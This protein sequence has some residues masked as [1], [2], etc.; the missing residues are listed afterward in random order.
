MSVSSALLHSPVTPTASKELPTPS[1]MHTL[2]RNTG[3]WGHFYRY[4]TAATSICRLQATGKHLCFS[5][6]AEPEQLA[7]ITL[8]PSD[9]QH[10][11]EYRHHVRYQF[12]QSSCTCET[13][14]YGSERKW[15]WETR[16]TMACFL[17]DC[18]IKRFRSKRNAFI[19]T[20]FQKYIA[21]GLCVLY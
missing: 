11:W 17:T 18:F 7:E 14:G 8:S 19:L 2:C 20:M 9:T 3:V 21:H 16:Y 6:P 5:I 1:C 4:C 15:Q 10:A 13:Q 12:C